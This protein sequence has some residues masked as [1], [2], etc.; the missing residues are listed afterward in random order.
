MSV[1][2]LTGYLA[3]SN[4]LTANTITS[5]GTIT[6]GEFNLTTDEGTCTIINS[7]ANLDIT[8][9]AGGITFIQSDL[10]LGGES[11]VF[12]CKQISLNGGI[13]SVNGD[14][15]LLWNGGVVTVTQ[16]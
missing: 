10:S 14:G 9:V 5:T 4:N 12:D 3:T 2:S 1:A 16:P 11:Q 7:G 6:G 15:A 13:L 8:P